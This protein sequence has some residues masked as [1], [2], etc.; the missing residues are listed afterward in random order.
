MPIGREVSHTVAFLP[1]AAA[2]LRELARRAPEIAAELQR[3]SAQLE[4]E[5]TDIEA[6]VERGFS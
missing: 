1:M 2:H 3:V 4:A 6:R 5:A